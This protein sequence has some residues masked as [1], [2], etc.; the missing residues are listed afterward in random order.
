[1]RYWSYLSSVGTSSTAH[2][3]A[4]CYQCQSDTGPRGAGSCRLPG[5]CGKIRL[6]WSEL[7]FSR[8]REAHQMK[9]STRAHYGIR[10][11]TVLA[12]AYGGRPVA[13]SEIAEVER[14]P[15]AYLEQLISPL[16]RA[17]FVAATRGA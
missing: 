11:L 7:V 14:L 8:H 2:G 16:R 6:V 10:M 1:A 17:G 3:M 4:A 9:V 15:L 13:L 12:R 5:G